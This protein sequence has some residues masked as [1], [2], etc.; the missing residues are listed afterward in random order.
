MNPPAFLWAQYHWSM[1]PCPIGPEGER[2]LGRRQ[3]LSQGGPKTLCSIS[4]SSINIDQHRST[5]INIDQFQSTSINIDQHR[6]IS[7]NFD[8]HRLTSISSINF[9]LIDLIKLVFLPRPLPQQNLELGRGENGNSV[10]SSIIQ[11]HPWA[12]GGDCGLHP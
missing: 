7:I 11:R 9:D 4:I 12:G 3:A 2:G 1:Q 5:S 6:S 10:F 8:Q